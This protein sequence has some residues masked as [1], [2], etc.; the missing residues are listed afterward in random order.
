MMQLLRNPFAF[1]K[2]YILKIYDYKMSP[3]GIVGKAG[4]KACERFF[5]GSSVDDS[6][7][8]GLAYINSVRDDEVEWGKTGSREKIIADFTQ[9]FQSYVSEVPSYDV[10]A[11]EKAIT[12][13]IEID[14]VK[15][16][17]P[18]KAIS[19]LIIRDHDGLTIV[20]HKFVS[21]YTDAEKEKG[22][23][24]IQGLFNYYTILSEFGEAPKRIVFN[25]CKVSK[26]KN[27]DHQLQPYIIEFAEHPEY[28]ALF[29]NLYNQCT[30]EIVRPDKLYLPNL[31]DMLNPNTLEDYRSQIITVEAPVVNHKTKQ[32]E[33]VEPKFVASPTDL[34]DNQYLPEE[35]KIRVK[36]QE[37]GI[38]VAMDETHKGG[39]IIQYTLK[40]SRGTKMTTFVRHAKDIA[41]ALKAKT[42]RVEAPIMGTDTV[43]IEVPN[44]DR[45][46]IEFTESLLIPDTLSIPIGVNVYGKPVVKLLDDMPHLLVAGATGSGKSVFINCAIKALTEQNSADALKL[47]LIDPKRVELARFKNVPHLLVPPIYDEEKATRSLNWLVAEM[48]IRYQKL[49]TAGSRNID[50]YN[51]SQADRMSKIVVV[52]DEFA[53]LILQAEDADPT[54]DRLLTAER[55]I[56]RLAQKARAIGIHLILGT[57]RPSVDVVTGLIKANLPCRISFMT[58]SA[59]DSQVILG[60]AG[61]EELIGKGD[62]LFMDSSVRGLQRLQG[63]LI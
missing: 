7:G 2:Q 20:D 3:A 30:R 43:G 10:V 24:I 11:V 53:D 12:A 33:Y 21:S 32:A 18:A 8:V 6:A 58:S 37:F 52:V 15:L 45:S 59:T 31:D 4:H 25:E 22:G 9:A 56:V 34:V 54:N 29:Q 14:G 35:E 1:K 27:G 41:I 51:R 42:I 23:F 40:P 57:Q 5:N 48:E 61:A 26:N 50:E 49:E 13:F 28:F 38:A 63:Y 36:L 44:P 17:L 60:E 55:A 47:V 19:D 46:F 62:M 16:A 39:S